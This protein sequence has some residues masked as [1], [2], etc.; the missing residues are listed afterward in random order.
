MPSTER[1]TMPAKAFS[2]LGLS[3]T[4]LQ[5]VDDLGYTEPTPVQAQAIPEVLAGHDLLAAAQTGT[6]KTAAF[7]LPV[8]D[9]LDHARRGQGPHVLVVTPTRELAQQIDDVC[10][11]IA[12]RTH[13]FATTVVG[14][15]GYQP[16][17]DALRRGCDILVA[18]PGRLVDLIEQ[19]VADLSGVQTLVLDEADRM[20]DMGFLPA[21]RRIVGQT[22]EDRQ[23]LLFS[24]TLD[25]SAIRGISDLVHDPVRVEIA[26]KGTVADT[27]DQFCLPVSLEAKNA[28]LAKVLLAEGPGHVIV[29]CRTKHRADACCRRLRRS[30]ISCAPIHGNRSQNQREHALADFRDEKV[31]VLVATDVLARGIDVSDVR[32]VVNFDV[33]ADPED[34]IHRIGRTGRAGEEGWALTFVTVD[35]VDDLY[36]IEALMQQ[37][38]PLYVSPSPL[39]R[40]EQPP[41]LDPNR[42]PP[43]KGGN[44]PGSGKGTRKKKRGQGGGHD[45][46]NGDRRSQ[47]S[48]GERG[49]Q[50]GN[51]SQGGNGRGGRGQAS[52]GESRQSKGRQPGSRQRTQSGEQQDR[53]QRETGRQNRGNAG[54]G[55][56]NR[57]GS[58]RGS[59]GRGGAG[60]NGRGG[61]Q[62]EAPRTPS[63][64][65]RHPGDRGGRH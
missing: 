48:R 54:R 61:S 44:R 39:D 51:G 20:L 10:Q 19:G 53:T 9:T 49:G 47:G 24:A 25:D 23:T 3:P 7:L 35:D 52:Q 21:M 6:G 15:V 31:D 55:D 34:Y 5:A 30:N 37:V 63:K 41:A 17:K 33:P 8:M 11:S 14:G 4:M 36:S 26:H 45:R 46:G 38:V 13:H 64:H 12:K 56:S 16:Q 65:T 62:A 59:S 18:T 60:R 28:L 43:S 40:G 22:P 58:G 27:I 42:Q 32:Y 1:T 57:S 29:F 2:D 50:G